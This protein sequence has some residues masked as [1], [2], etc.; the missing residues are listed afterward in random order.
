MRTSDF[1]SRV[2]MTADPATN[3]LVI[4]AAPQ[5]WEVLRN[6]IAELDVPRI[7]VFVQAIIVEVS[8]ERQR[9]MG[10]D[11]Q[12]ATSISHSVLGLGNVNF[13]NIQTALGNPLGLTGLGLGL[14]SG[15]SVASFRAAAAAVAGTT[16]GTTTT[17]SVPCDVAC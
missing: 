13:G 15:S 1:T 5:D 10:V 9:Q 4:S 12:A 6:I 8:S 11:F 3:A 14:A 7:Q 2:T 17:M 16:T